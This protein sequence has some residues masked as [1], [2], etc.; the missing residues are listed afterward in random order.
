M[1]SWRQW[2]VK[3]AM[4]LGLTM[5]LTV[6]LPALSVWLS[7]GHIQIGGFYAAATLLLMSVSLYVSSLSASGLRA[8]LVSLPASL[9]IVFA[10]LASV[11]SR[12][13]FQLTLLPTS[14]LALLLLVILYFAL[15]NHRS[16]ERG[17]VRVSQQVF[18]IGG[19]VLVGA[20]ILALVRG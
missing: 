20:E 4:A 7:G 19:V 14:L 2:A 17:L 12:P 5:L 15:L 3:V 9:V 16:A 13:G 8:L 18:C 6:A 10:V 1:A 11:S